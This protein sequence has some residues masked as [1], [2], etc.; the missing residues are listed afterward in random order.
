MILVIIGVCLVLAVIGFIGLL[1]LSLLA[2]LGSL[3]GGGFLLL[4]I[5]YLVMRHK[6]KRQE[7]KDEDNSSSST[8]KAKKE[9]GVSRV[10]W[11]VLG[12]LLIAL[13][14]LAFYSSATA[15]QA[16]IKI[17]RALYVAAQKSPQ[18]QIVIEKL[19]GIA[20]LNPDDRV[21]V[22][23]AIMIRDDDKALIFRMY[24]EEQGNT[25]SITYS[26]FDR[27]DS[28][29]LGVWT[30]DQDPSLTGHWSLKRDQNIPG[31]YEG[32]VDGGRCLPVMCATFALKKKVD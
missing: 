7:K 28:D 15:Y 14:A 23:D 17:K 8:T 19:P 16:E 9:G 2:S 11:S 4:L 32:L 26:L 13:I 18:Y 27:S 10:I 21:I 1:G 29:K 24:R 6:K 5:I 25:K 3:G 22:R 20:G 12:I 30:C 31:G